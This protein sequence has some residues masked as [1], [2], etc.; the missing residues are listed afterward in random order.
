M[1]ILTAPAISVNRSH[2]SILNIRATAPTTIVQSEQQK[3]QA[4]LV[5]YSLAQY[6]AQDV[7]RGEVGIYKYII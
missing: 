4:Y 1:T 2:L 3:I 6:H 7:L 5:S